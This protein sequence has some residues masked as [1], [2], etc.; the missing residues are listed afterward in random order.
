MAAH[1]DGDQDRALQLAKITAAGS[2]GRPEVLTAVSAAQ[3]LE[4][5]ATSLGTVTCRP[6]G[7]LST[8]GNATATAAA[9]SKA[10]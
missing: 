10:T 6:Y 5:A 1:G 8:E 2:C 4:A 9:M 7:M 3:T